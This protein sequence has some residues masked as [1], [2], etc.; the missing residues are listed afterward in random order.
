[1]FTA[2]V[3]KVI[4]QNPA[5]AEVSVIGVKD[6]EWGEA[7]K[8]VCVLKPGSSLSKQE[9]IDFVA[10]RIARYKKLKYVEFVPSLLKTPDG[11]IDREKIKA[12]Y[13]KA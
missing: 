7:I 1:M 3:E 12:E 2:E 11:T 5:V 13:G 8:A 10:S 9:L 4:L 6:P